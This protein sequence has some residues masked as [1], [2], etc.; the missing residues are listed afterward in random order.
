MYYLSNTPKIQGRGNG[1]YHLREVHGLFGENIK[2]QAFK[3][4]AISVLLLV[5]TKCESVT[6]VSNVAA[7]SEK[8]SGRKN[9]ST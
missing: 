8:I 7:V 4:S 9:V 1:Q 2:D 3:L 6:V 5:T